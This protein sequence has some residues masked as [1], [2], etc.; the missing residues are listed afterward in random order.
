M[1]MIKLEEIYETYIEKTSS[2]KRNENQIPPESVYV[3]IKNQTSG[4]MNK[5]QKPPG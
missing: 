5:E 4:R 2:R 1:D 3:Q